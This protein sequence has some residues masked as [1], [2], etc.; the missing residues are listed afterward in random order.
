MKLN[1]LNDLEKALETCTWLCA[2]MRYGKNRLCFNTKTG[3]MLYQ[4]IETGK[5]YDPYNVEVDGTSE[6]IFKAYLDKIEI[7]KE[8]AYVNLRNSGVFGAHT[9]MRSMSWNLGKTV[10]NK[11]KV[12]HPE[13]FI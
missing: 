11:I 8:R 6:E 2:S 4:R 5:N 1:K 13:Y 9:L 12:S 7:T 10:I 3:V